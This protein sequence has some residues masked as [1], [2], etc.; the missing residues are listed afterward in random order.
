ALSA[1]S[2]T[3]T[4][5]VFTWYTDAA[6]TNVAYVGSSFT[7]PALA[8]T[9][10]YYVTVK[11]DNSCA[12]APADAKVVTV[13]VK[14]Y[15][16]AADINLNNLNICSGNSATLM[17][18]SVTVTQPIFTWYSDA[19][20]TVPVFTGPTYNVSVTTTTSFYVTVKGTNKCENAAAD[21]KVV[22]VNV[23]PLATTTDIIVAGNTNACAASSAVLTASSTTVTNPVFTW[24]SDAALTNVAFV[25][26]VFNTPAL[27]TNTTYYVT[28]RGDNK[29]ENAASTAKIVTVT[30]NAAPANP[31][32]AA[33]GTTVCSGNATTLNIQ[34]PQA[35]V[36]YQWYDAASGGNLLTTGTSFTTGVL[37][38]SVSYYVEAIGAGG[39]VSSSARTMVMVTVNPQPFVPI[40]ASNSV[41]ACAGS[42]AALSVTNTQPGVTYN[43]YTTLTGGAIVGSG[44]TFTT[45]ALS[46]NVTYYVEAVSGTCTSA[47]R[48]PVAITVSPLP[49]APLLVSA[50]N[51]LIC[52]GSTTILN[53]SSPDAGL[54]YRWYNVSSGGTVLGQ[55]TS[56][57]TPALTTTTIFYVE[58]V[59][60]AG[61][62]S[63]TRTATTVTVLPVLAAPVVRVQTTTPA[64]VTFAW[65]PV[66]NATGYEV[67]LDNGLSWQSPSNGAASTSHVVTGL[68]PDQGAVI[69]VRALGQ[70]GCQTSANSIPV[71]GKASNPIGNDIYIPNAFTPNNDGKNDVFLVY[72]TTIASVKMSV[73]TQWGQLIYQVNSTTT[74]WDGTYKG[75][76]QPSGVYV[77]MIE[78]ESND[79]TRV[80]K[81]GTVTLI[82]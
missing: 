54:T 65:N 30:V 3:V 69:L 43:W 37:N 68:K 45:P 26:A 25:G 11:G 47:N 71:T 70:I 77:Y 23:N 64:S 41:S 6:L 9:T 44:S 72:G 63:A 10:T 50:T 48:T 82:R 29:C 76:A 51:G 24:Y 81:K 38:G 31:V 16:T 8:V 79:G 27:T 2:G 42:T 60:A 67:S 66:A 58:S 56:F 32:I 35:G 74:G 19:S 55:G 33:G 34:N 78:I 57:I 49:V 13:T 36:T 39:C 20:L 62:S 40:V 7:T 61:C 59:S 12:N 4:N 14:D 15:A 1:S 28:V 73:Y 80:M 17:A 75:V 53:V 5:P 46:G 21:G 22:T 18:S 52:S